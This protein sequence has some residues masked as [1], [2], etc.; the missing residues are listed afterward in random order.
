MSWSELA[1]KS[2]YHA[3]QSLQVRSATEAAV[4]SSPGEKGL[5]S[6]RTIFPVRSQIR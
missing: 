5:S 1:R 6:L 3:S 2:I 4:A